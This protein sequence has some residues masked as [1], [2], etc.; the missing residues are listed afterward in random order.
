M[1]RRLP[2]D[3]RLDWRDPNMPVIR[4]VW[5]NGKTE[6]REIPPDVLKQY[7]ANKIDNYQ[8]WHEGYYKDDPSYY[9]AK[10]VKKAVD[11]QK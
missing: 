11:N 5:I 4:K 9:W 7:Y 6:V 2:P 3:N 10:K 8:Y 1:R